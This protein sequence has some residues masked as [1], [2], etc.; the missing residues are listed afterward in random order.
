MRIFY[1]IAFTTYT[2]ICMIDFE[3]DPD[4]WTIGWGAIALLNLALFIDSKRT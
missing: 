3:K 2:G 4:V 1:I